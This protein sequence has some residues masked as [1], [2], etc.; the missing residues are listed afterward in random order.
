MGFVINICAYWDWDRTYF[1]QSMCETESKEKAYKMFR[2]TMSCH[3]PDTLEGAEND[4]G[5]SIEI[6][7]KVEQIII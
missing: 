2:Q 6:V 3:L 1:V 5:I 7:A 4:D